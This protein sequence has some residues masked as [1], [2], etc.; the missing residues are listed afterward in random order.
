MQHIIEI[1]DF[2]APELDPYARLTQAQLRNRLEPEKGIF[3][4]ESPK[5]IARALDAGYRPLSLLMER[6]QIT[7]PAAE[8]LTRC[9]EAPVYTADRELLA[10]LTGF[11]LTRG[12]LC[13]FQRPAPR[14]A[15]ELCRNARRVA[16]LE[17]IVD[18]T[19]VGAIFRSAAALNM[20]A[21]L[22]TPSCCDPLCR[23]AVRVSM[24]TVFQVPWAQIGATPA[25]WPEKGIEELHALGF[26]TAAMALS[27]RSV[28]ID[29]ETLAAEPR[30]AIIMG[31]EGDG[32]SHST[33]AACD[34]TVKIP[35]SHGVDSLNVAAASA[36][37]FWQL[38]KQ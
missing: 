24:G 38:G 19:N 1:T 23:R 14:T 22:I 15:A 7:G 11:E 3:I 17:G 36:V 33:I 26:Q 16:V 32:L 8:I 5:V 29:D 13:A 6:R 10:A 21:V 2:H 25:D 31:T 34:Y 18:S 9:G 35:M 30:L 4:A 28:R 27:D 20:D 37:A 12:V